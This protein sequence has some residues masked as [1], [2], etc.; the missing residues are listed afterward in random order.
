MDVGHKRSLSSIFT[1]LGKTGVDTDLLKQRI[2][3][4]VVKT[5]IS[6]Q[7][8]LAHMYRLSQPNNYANDMC[9]Q[10]LGF[11]IILDSKMQPFLLEVNHNPSL[12]ADT[13]LDKFIKKKLVKDTLNLLHIDTKAKA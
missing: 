9:F 10:I 5:L 2:N 11:D 1:Y 3:D 7:P 4:L 8:F 12:V 6:A 13:P